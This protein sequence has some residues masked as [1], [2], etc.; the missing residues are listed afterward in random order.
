[1]TV[2]VNF[3]DETQKHISCVFAGP[4]KEGSY[5]NLG[6]VEEDDPRLLEFLSF[7]PAGNGP[8]LAITD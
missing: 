6:E 7:F 2:Y 5:E 1:M 4:Q 3:N 8:M